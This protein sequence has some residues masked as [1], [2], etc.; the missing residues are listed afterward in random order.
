MLM[1]CSGN[2]TLR[3]ANLQAPCYYQVSWVIL[4]CLQ[5]CEFQLRYQWKRRE[6]ACVAFFYN[7]HC[8]LAMAFNTTAPGITSSVP[9]DSGS[10]EQ[11][12]VFDSGILPLGGKPRWRHPAP[13]EDANASHGQHQF[14]F[15]LVLHT[16]LNSVGVETVCEY[17]CVALEKTDVIKAGSG[18]WGTAPVAA[19]D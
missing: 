14:W 13:A 17:M 9:I 12:N 11:G 19:G 8:S 1:V 15:P 4:I 7:K 3:T 5:F 2:P 10:R 6:G 16:G 18:L